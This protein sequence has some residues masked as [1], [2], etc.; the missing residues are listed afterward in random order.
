LPS[1]SVL[2]VDI[3]RELVTLTFDLLALVSG[4]NGGSHGR[5]S[6]KFEAPT[7]ICS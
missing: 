3:L 2:V 1:Y 5:L 6:I 7:A 4:H